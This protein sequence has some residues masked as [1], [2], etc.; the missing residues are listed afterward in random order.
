MSRSVVVERVMP[1]PPQKV[2]RALTQAPLIEA[3]LM[4]TDFEPV[5]GRRFQ[6]RAE[7]NPQW[8][9]VVDCEV[10]EIDAPRRLVIAWGD[11]SAANG[12]VKTVVTWTLTPVDGGT[13]VRMEQSGFREDQEFAARGASF[14]WQR[15]LDG[16]ERVAGE[17]VTAEGGR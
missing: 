5:V 16:L 17:V 14:G 6:F 1:H 11:G 13:G 15:L 3:W 4:K 7:P 8:S 9:G 2:W 12:G 10:L